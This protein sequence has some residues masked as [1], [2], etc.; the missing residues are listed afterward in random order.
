MEGKM[1]IAIRGE[2][3][4]VRTFGDRPVVRR[5]WDS[6]KGLIYICSDKQFDMMANGEDSPPPIG[7]PANDVY[8]YDEV[9]K[10]FLSSDGHMDWT[11]LNP[12]V[13]NQKNG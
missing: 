9:S 1:P 3:V 12:F 11:K 2:M 4:L 8:C 13:G 5:V 7:F 10:K 6:A